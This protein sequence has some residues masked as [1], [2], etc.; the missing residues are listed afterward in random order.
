MNYLNQGAKS[1]VEQCLSVTKADRV[2]IV[3]DKETQEIGT[4]LEK[5]A[6][7]LTNS[8]KKIIIEDYVERPALELPAKLIEEINR[9]KPTTSIYAAQA[10]TGELPDFRRPLIDLFFKDHKCK[11]AHMVGITAQLMED[12]MLQDYN[13]VYKVTHNVYNIVKNATKILVTDPHGTNLEAEFDPKKIKWIPDD[14]KIDNKKWKNLPSGEVFTSAMNANGTFV[15][16]VLGDSLKHYGE[17]SDP[18]I[19]NLKNGYITSV[20]VTKSASDKTKN[21]KNDFLEYVQ[22]YKDSNR[23]GEF[24]IGTLVGLKAFT[25]NLLQDEKFP[26]VHIA[27]G[28]PYPEDTGQTWDSPSHIDIIAKKTTI[29]VEDNKGETQTIMTNGVFTDHILN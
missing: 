19:V 6:L 4:A 8:V 12:G 22:Q 28:H 15:A 23:L 10:L 11:H 26:G 18:I 14:G 7:K 20:D 9:F 16:W 17:L 27:F 24:G 29:V 1:A 2:F 3:T 13:E 21:A 25:G 5:E